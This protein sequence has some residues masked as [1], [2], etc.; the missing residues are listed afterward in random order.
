V[1]FAGIPNQK[2]RHAREGGHPTS[3]KTPKEKLDSRLRGNDGINKGS[4][5]DH[6]DLAIWQAP[7]AL[8]LGLH[9]FW[10]F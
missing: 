1:I 3:V 5:K 10:L 2:F 4:G 9:L 7:P 8:K 6:F